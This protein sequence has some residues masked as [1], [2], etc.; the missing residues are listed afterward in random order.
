MQTTTIP[1]LDLAAMRAGDMISWHRRPLKLTSDPR[2]VGGEWS[3]R[4]TWEGYVVTVTQRR[5]E[6][7]MVWTERSPPPRR[8]PPHTR[9]GDDARRAVRN[10]EGRS[11]RKRNG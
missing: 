9:G 5:G 2:R 8:E 6:E 7:V 1:L 3:A 10:G 11:E 4:G